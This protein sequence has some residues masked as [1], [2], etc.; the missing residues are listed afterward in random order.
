MITKMFLSYLLF[1]DLF[2]EMKKINYSMNIHSFY[3]PLKVMLNLYSY[4][5]ISIEH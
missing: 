3:I 1:M 4:N 5:Q 2:L